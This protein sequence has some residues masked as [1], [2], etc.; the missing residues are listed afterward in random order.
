MSRLDPDGDR[1]SVVVLGTRRVLFEEQIHDEVRDPIR[2]IAE[3]GN[4]LFGE[5][6]GVGAQQFAAAIDRDDI[7]R[8]VRHRSTPI[9]F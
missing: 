2:V 5:A 8:R 1:T 7:R 3:C 9:R 6:I 4:L